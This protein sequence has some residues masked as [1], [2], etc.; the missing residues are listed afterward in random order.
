MEGATGPRPR[1]TTLTARQW[2]TAGP[3]R[4]LIEQPRPRGRR[5]P[6]D[7]VVYGGTGRAARDWKS[8]DAMVRT[9]TDLRA[10]DDAR[11]VRPAGRGDP[12]PRV[13]TAGPHR[14]LEPRPDWATW[15]EFRRLEHLG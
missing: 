12:D 13:G 15:P 9:L 8:F 14:Q 4:M 11:P 5:A 7:L 1:G 2:S 10:D 3:L 6:D